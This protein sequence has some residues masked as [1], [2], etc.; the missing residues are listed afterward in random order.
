MSKAKFHISS[1]A[2][3][4][5]E[6]ILFYTTAKWSEEQADRYYML[7]IGEMEY[8]SLNP[9]AGRSAEHIRPG[10][11]IGIVQSHLIFY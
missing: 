2:I 11:R 6:Q 10:Y 5:L 1:K 9:H 8:L 4:D 7:L 3:E